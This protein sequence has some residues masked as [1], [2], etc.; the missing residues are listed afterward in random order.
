GSCG[1]PDL[2]VTGMIAV[3]PSP[4]IRERKRIV[5]DLP[6][7]DQPNRQRWQTVT[8]SPPSMGYATMRSPSTAA[9]HCSLGAIACSRRSV[10][11]G[12]GLPEVTRYVTND[13]SRKNT[14]PEEPTPKQD[15]A[16]PDARMRGGVR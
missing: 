13:G 6:S 4:P 10:T 5:N 1:R 12:G 14:S 11:F 7:R 16:M 15:S 9:P 2:S 3:I 8:A